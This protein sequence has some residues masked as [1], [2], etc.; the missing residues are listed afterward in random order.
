MEGWEVEGGGE[1]GMGWGWKFTCQWAPTLISTILL[2]PCTHKISYSDP[3]E[4]RQHP[5]LFLIKT[6]LSVEFTQGGEVQEKRTARFSAFFRGTVMKGAVCNREHAS[7]FTALSSINTMMYQSESGQEMDG[8][9]ILGGQG[10]LNIGTIYRCLI[11][12]TG[13]RQ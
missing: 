8:T 12:D 4:R 1:M 11:K 5:I 13:N 7:R 10:E 6:I 2:P 3:R 9:E